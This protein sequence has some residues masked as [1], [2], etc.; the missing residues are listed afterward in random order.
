MI[1]NRYKVLGDVGLGTFGR[2]VEC[3]DMKRRRQVAVKV[4]RK[5]IW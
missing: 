5:V 1:G 2:V 4:V 3:L